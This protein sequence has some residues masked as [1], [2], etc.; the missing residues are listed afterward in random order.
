MAIPIHQKEERALMDKLYDVN[1]N[2]FFVQNH[3]CYGQNYVNCFTY[4]Q[5]I[6]GKSIEGKKTMHRN[7]ENYGNYF[8][9]R[10]NKS[11]V[12]ALSLD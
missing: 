7:S 4:R 10:M 9:E 12:T 3:T 1:A 2:T 5:M 6:T 11:A 8:C